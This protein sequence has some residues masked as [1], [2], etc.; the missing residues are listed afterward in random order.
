MP[1]KRCEQDGNQGWRWGRKGKCY[2]GDNAK[3]EA[4]KQGIA[5]EG[6]EIVRQILG[7]NR[8]QVGYGPG[9]KGDVP[10]HIFLDMDGVLVDFVGGVLEL[11]GVDH[12]QL[13][14]VWPV[15]QHPF[16]EEL[17]VKEDEFYERI[18][19]NNGKMWENLKP[20][21]FATWFYE[22][23]KSI[24]E[25]TILSS[26]AGADSA[27]GKIR[28]L[29]RW[30]GNPLFNDYILT[31]KKKMCASPNCILIDDKNEN[32]EEFRKAG[33]N[34]ILFPQRWNNRHKLAAKREPVTM[35]LKELQALVSSIREK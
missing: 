6:P 17:G 31:S 13:Y 35:V 32:V 19:A 34:A 22:T 20:Y 4:I 16:H 2:T 15:N 24:A 14:R 30:T 8:E 9:D 25:T 12:D 21:P 10:V 11:F 29:Q 1:P 26:P 33:G 5:I 23:C 27:A 3:Q 18:N 28:F 7:D